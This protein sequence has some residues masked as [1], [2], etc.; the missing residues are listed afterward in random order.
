MLFESGKKIIQLHENDHLQ[1]CLLKEYYEY[2]PMTVTVAVAMATA[3]VR[4]V[5][6]ALTIMAAVE[7][8]AGGSET[9]SQL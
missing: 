2:V 8:M 1:Y 9:G 3:E 7:S 5:S 4:L 6:Q